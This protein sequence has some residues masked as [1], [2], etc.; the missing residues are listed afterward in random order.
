[1]T[2]VS[3]QSQ[4]VARNFLWLSLQEMMI[5]LLGLASA[6]YLARKFSPADYGALG[7]ALAIVGF[8]TM[9]VSAGT[10]VR[11]TRLTALDHS[12][13]PHT[14]AVVSGIRVTAAAVVFSGLIILGPTVADFL[15]IPPALLVL[16]GL[17]LLRPALTVQWAFRGQD[18]MHVTAASEVVEKSVLFIGLIVF[19]HGG[20]EQ[21]L[22]VPLVETVAALVLVYIL[23]S[24]LEQKFS[25]LRIRFRVSEWPQFLKESIPITLATL[26]G[27]VQQNCGIIL[28]GVLLTADAAARFLVSQKIML[29]ALT[30]LLVVN[31]SA[32]PSISRLLAGK[33]S[34]ALA[35]QARLLRL[36]FAVMIPLTLLVGFYAAAILSA[37]FGSTYS[38]E[39]PLLAILLCALP[40]IIFGQSLQNVLL[41]SANPRPVL[42]AK[43]CGA[44]AMVLLMFLLIPRM[45]TTGAALSLV[46]GE[47]ISMLLL[48]AGVRRKLHSSLWTA[49]TSGTVVAGGIMALM[50]VLTVDWL[51]A[52]RVPLVVLTYMAFIYA[53]KGVSLGELKDLPRLL[54]ALIRKGQSALGYKE[55]L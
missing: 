34:E 27:S 18:L 54:T 44:V 41:A 39:G 7:I 47:S 10:G 5:R 33:V 25:P 24:R 17:L 55:P 12:T 6:I 1:M 8:L 20:S 29:T 13:I 11:A 22:R 48:L 51:A 46:G 2:K 38:G 49:A 36:F 15:A 23:Y 53:F 35:L 32:F 14:F 37:L 16:T 26:M 28:L 52:V 43:S 42:T 30:L 4:R 9:V 45:E 40:F 31:N 19:V 3:D 50:L 21:L